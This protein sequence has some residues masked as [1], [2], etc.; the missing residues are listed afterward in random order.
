MDIWSIFGR[1]PH[2]T[3]SV[4]LGDITRREVDAIVNAADE[5]LLGGTGVDGAIREAAGPRLSEACRRIAPLHGGAKATPGFDLPAR[6]VI[7]VAAP[8]HGSQ[9]K[10]E[11]L[12]ISFSQCIDVAQ[13]LDVETLAFP[14]L[15]AGVFCWDPIDSALAAKMAIR[16]AK[17]RGRLRHVQMVAFSE[18]DCMVLAKVFETRPEVTDENRVY[19]AGAI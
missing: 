8:V 11:H 19:H 6:W 10:V 15:G 12:A 16:K 2:L 9:L 14:L 18:H 5:T 17:R 13:S 1:R 4:V 3:T 7:H